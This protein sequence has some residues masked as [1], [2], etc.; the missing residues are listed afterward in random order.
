[1]AAGMGSRY[2]GVKQIEAVGLSGETIMDYSVFDALRAGFTQ[3]VLIIRRDIENDVRACIGKRLEK[4]IPLR[5]AYQELGSLP[6]GFAVP[7]GRVKPWGTA[8]ALLCAAGLADGPFALINA[9]DFY[10]RDAFAVMGAYLAAADPR[11]A[12]FAMAGYTLEKTL[13]E[14]GSVS[15][16]ICEV[17][18]GELSSITEHTKI[19]KTAAGIISRRPSGDIKLS[20]RETASMNL[21]GFTS[22]LFPLLESEFRSFLEQRGGDPAAECYIPA[23]VTSL[24]RSG[25][26]RVRVLPTSASWFGV[27]YKEDKPAV[28]AGIRALIEKGEYPNPLWG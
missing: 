1:M 5:Y 14:N 3:A 9:D 22:R 28:Q 4:H 2:G 20:G 24:I 17:S 23:V 16:G 15:R 25:Q 21:F 12:A 10:G 6:E 26:A 13:S 11:S 18:G 8:H 7:K 27:T 19:E